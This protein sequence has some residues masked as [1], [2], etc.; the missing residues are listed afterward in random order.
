MKK[1]FTL[2]VVFT[3]ASLSTFAQLN[4]KFEGELRTR[5]EIDDLDFNA[6]TGIHNYINNRARLSAIISNN[7]DLEFVFRIIDARVFGSEASLQSNS[8][9]LDLNEGYLK[10][11]KIPGNSS[12]EDSRRSITTTD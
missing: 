12:S 6:N 7:D 4:V 2:F 10:I 3:L 11:K 9:N 8:A 1:L 5:L